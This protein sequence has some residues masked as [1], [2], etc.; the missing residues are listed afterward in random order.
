MSVQST[1]EGLS[2]T[3]RAHSV[4][5]VSQVAA[6]WLYSLA[7]LQRTCDAIVLLLAPVMT[8]AEALSLLLTSFKGVSEP[9]IPRVLDQITA[10]EADQLMQ[11]IYA[12]LGQ[13]QA[14]VS[15]IMLRW[16]DHTTAAFGVG[17]ILRTLT[18]CQL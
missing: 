7:S 8:Q 10:T 6:L 1:I 3:L 14:S 12:G 5:S 18:S 9:Q 4:G 17:C 16:H 2:S 13:G 11:L 15:Q